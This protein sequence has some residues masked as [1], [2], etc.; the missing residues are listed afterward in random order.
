M[1]LVHCT[2]PVRGYDV[3]SCMSYRNVVFFLSPLRRTHRSSHHTDSDAFYAVGGGS[4]GLASS[5]TTNF[6]PSYLDKKYQ[7]EDTL[8][9]I[10]LTLCYYH[11][12]ATR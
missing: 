4:A 6:I 7:R 3:T 8:D 5:V 12:R 1:L 11:H 9:L 10:L 2:Y